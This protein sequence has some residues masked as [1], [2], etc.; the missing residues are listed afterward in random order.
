MIENNF[1]Q[2][3]EEILKR[4]S[5][6][7]RVPLIP[8]KR[9]KVIEDD[10]VLA[11][12]K[13]TI[14]KE[15]VSQVIG[16]LYNL[17]YKGLND[18]IIIASKNIDKAYI[19]FIMK[20]KLKGKLKEIL[21]SKVGS[22]NLS[23]SKLDRLAKDNIPTNTIDRVSTKEKYLNKISSMIPV[24]GLEKISNLIDELG[25][26]EYFHYKEMFNNFC[27]MKLPELEYSCLRCNGRDVIG[28]NWNRDFTIQMI[29]I[30]IDSSDLRKE[31]KTLYL[32]FVN[33]L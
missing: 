15:Y 27:R 30:M 22:Y 17:T 29:R 32:K 31:T 5:K 13:L 26:G 14:S 24:E 3:R 33:L 16:D 11:R 8:I 19:I 21:K 10:N 23:N 9:L 12:F 28:C 18:D 1:K 7:L 4:I 2:S 20:Y 6:E 25:E